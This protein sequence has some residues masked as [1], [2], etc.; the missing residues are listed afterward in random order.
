MHD[1][2]D[3]TILASVN[4]PTV[5][6]GVTMAGHSDR[7]AGTVQEVFHIGKDVAITCTIDQHLPD[8]RYRTRPEG[9]RHSFRRRPDGSWYE[10]RL[11]RDSGQWQKRSH[12]LRLTLG[13]RSGHTDP[14]Y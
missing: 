11:S 1:T 10:I 14:H 3:M 6:M 4:E 12:G 9:D 7:Q 8:G 5:G 2:D 13:E